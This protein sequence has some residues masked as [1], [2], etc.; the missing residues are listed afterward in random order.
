R[1]EMCPFGVRVSVMEPGGFRTRMTDPQQLAETLERLWEQLPEEK[2]AAYGRPYLQRY[3]AGTRLLHW[4]SSARLARVV[5]GIEHALLSHC[6][7]SR[8]SAGW[9]AKLLYLPLSYAPTWLADAI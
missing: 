4:L 5:D 9:D 1:R 8:Y 3:M 7:R 6:P 2:R